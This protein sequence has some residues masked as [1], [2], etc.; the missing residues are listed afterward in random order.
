MAGRLVIAGCGHS[1]LPLLAGL[2]DVVKA[3]RRVTV[4]NS[5]SYLYYSA[6][7]SGLLSMMYCPE[8]T[9]FNVREM[10]EKAGAEF[11]ED[12]VIGIDPV[13]RTLILEKPPPIS[14]DVV[15]F[16]LG[17]VVSLPEMHGQEGADEFT[18]KPIRN[19]Y[20]GR[21]RI[22]EKVSNSGT[23]RLLVIGG[24]S[25]G[26]EIAGNAWRLATTLDSHA[27]IAVVSAER[28]L[29]SCS[30]RASEMAME[31]LTARDIDVHENVRVESLGRGCARLSS[32]KELPYD[33]AF[34]ATGVRPV[35][36]FRNSGMLVGDDGGL[37]VNE[38]LQSPAYPEIFGGGDCISFAAEELPKN[39]VYA[40]RE[41]PV[42]QRNL[43]AA[44]KGEDLTRFHPQ[45]NYLQI[46]NMGDGTGLGIS[47]GISGM[48]TIAMR[49][50]NYIDRRF[51]RRYQISGE[52]REMDAPPD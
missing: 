47:G 38:F 35:P 3:G 24:G 9:R 52:S 26:V 17:S 50:K 7:G 42:L 30:E 46:L 2:A 49:L 8:E 22:R 25:S 43:A 41:G 31:S 11:V 12:N 19:L 18:V 23:V 32:G 36:L 48:S 6:M 15:S 45:K 14:Y 16:D 44:L 29:D 34:V 33:V 51:M 13:S 39:G 1:H 20:E 40:V 4:I 28:L 10:A 27:E 37:V 21:E 5:S